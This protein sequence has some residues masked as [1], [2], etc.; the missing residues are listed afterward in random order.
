MNVTISE[1]KGLLT[2]LVR[3]AEGGEDIVLTRHGRPVVALK[4]LDAQPRAWT[5]AELAERRRILLEISEKASHEATP[6]PDA[7]HSADFL[8]GDDGMPA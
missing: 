1:A 7:A 5:P 8:Y 2:E 6:G 3:R 4:P